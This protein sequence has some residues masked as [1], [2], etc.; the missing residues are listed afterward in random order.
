MKITPVLTPYSSLLLDFKQD[1]SVLLKEIISSRTVLRP[2][3]INK[4]VI[5]YGAGN[6]G[7]MAKDFF[8]YLNIPILYIVDTTAQKR[9]T[10]TYWRNTKIIYPHQVSRKDKVNSL[11]VICIVT[12]PLIPLRKKLLIDG[13]QDVAFFYDIAEAYAAKHPLSNGWFL[14]ELNENQQKKIEKVFFTLA[15]DLSRAHYLQMLAWRKLRLELNFGNK[16]IRSKNRFFIPEVTAIL[17]HD[18]IFVDGGAH[19][20]VVIEKFLTVTGHKYRKIYAIEPDPKNFKKLEEHLRQTPRVE[21]LRTALTSKS[22]SK[23]FYQGFDLAS[24]LSS[25]GNVIVKTRSLDSLKIKATFVKLHLEGGELMALKGGVKTI[26]QERPILT[27]TIYHHP[28]GAWRIPLWIITNTKNY[29]YYLRLHSWA[30]TGA[31]FYALPRSEN[32]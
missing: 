2:R 8:A 19:T 5:I 4:P 18:E 16:E 9:L 1:Q 29:D 11:L 6:L 15:D 23:R 10:E 13:W 14:G 7:R 20:G 22:G 12:T 25:H 28:D 24:K 26:H 27:V 21:L 17:D 31:V 3:Q 30:G 32:K